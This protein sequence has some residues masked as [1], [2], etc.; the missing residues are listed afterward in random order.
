MCDSFSE[1]ECQTQHRKLN[2]WIMK[3]RQYDYSANLMITETQGNKR[4]SVFYVVVK[5][6]PFSM[7]TY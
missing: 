1:S 5:K 7:L 3:F 2:L 6:K 4:F